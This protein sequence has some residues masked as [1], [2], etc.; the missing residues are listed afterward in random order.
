M[1]TEEINTVPPKTWK[2]EVFAQ[3]S[4]AQNALVFATFEEAFANARDLRN[5]WMLV[6]DYRA[7]ESTDAVNYRW[8]AGQLEEVK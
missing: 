5:R 1:T 7:V 4:W 8:I 6:E 3:G 2:P